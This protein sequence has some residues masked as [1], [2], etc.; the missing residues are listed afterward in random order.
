MFYLFPR[1]GPFFYRFYE[2]LVLCS[3]FF[4]GFLDHERFFK[5]FFQ[6]H[7]FYFFSKFQFLGVFPHGNKCGSNMSRQSM[8]TDGVKKITLKVNLV[9]APTDLSPTWTGIF[10]SDFFV[11]F[12]FLKCS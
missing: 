5:A 1:S 6:G 4:W 11:C 7:E 8:V 10:F 3:F 2:M 9:T 12:L